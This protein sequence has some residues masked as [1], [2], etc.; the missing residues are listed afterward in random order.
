[1][2]FPAL[3][4]YPGLPFWLPDNQRWVMMADDYDTPVCY[5]FSV[6]KRRLVREI[7]F[8]PILKKKN[9]DWHEASAWIVGVTRSGRVIACVKQMPGADKLSLFD[10]AVDVKDKKPEQ[11]HKY[12]IRLPRKAHVEEASL[13]AKENKLAWIQSWNNPGGQKH[14]ELW[15]SNLDG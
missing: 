13:F 9:E 10:F 11:P 1:R 4:G 6:E 8:P 15:I 14:V 5:V 2:A 12:T 3:F 7:R